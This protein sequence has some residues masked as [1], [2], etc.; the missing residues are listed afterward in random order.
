MSVATNTEVFTFMQ[1]AADVVTAQGANVTAIIAGVTA[2][3]EQ[4]IG[5][6]LKQQLL[7]ATYSRTG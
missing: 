6:R 3:I 7:Q 5:A 4:M 2:E 1:T